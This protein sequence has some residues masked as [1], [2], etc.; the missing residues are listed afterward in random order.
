MK[1]KPKRAR[2]RLRQVVMRTVGGRSDLMK[3]ENKNRHFNVVT[4][5]DEWL[6]G[7]QGKESFECYLRPLTAREFGPRRKRGGAK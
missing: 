5:K 3:I 1:P 4:C 2:F 7:G 6:Y